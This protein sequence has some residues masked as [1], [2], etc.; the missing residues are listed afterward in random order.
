VNLSKRKWDARRLFCIDRSGRDAVSVPSKV[1]L[2]SITIEQYILTQVYPTQV[3]RFYFKLTG[4]WPNGLD[5]TFSQATCLHADPTN[6]GGNLV[7][8]S[9]TLRDRWNVASNA[10]ANDVGICQLNYKTGQ[11]DI[12][13]I[14]HVFTVERGKVST[15]FSGA[16]ST[17]SV[18]YRRIAHDQG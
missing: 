14:S 2:W 15:A 8:G 9:I 1:S 17:F 5:Q 7:T 3:H 18:M 16:P 13:E 11:F 12:V 10:K 4:N 6:H